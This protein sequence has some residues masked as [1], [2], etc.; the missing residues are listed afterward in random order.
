MGGCMSS[1]PDLLNS[2]GEGCCIVNRYV[3]GTLIP[4]TDPSHPT[5]DTAKMSYGPRLCLPSLRY[6]LPRQRSLL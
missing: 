4:A 2:L 3:P 5:V 1:T 6:G